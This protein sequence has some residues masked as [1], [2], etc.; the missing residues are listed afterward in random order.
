MIKEHRTFDYVSRMAFGV[1]IALLVFAIFTNSLIMLSPTLNSAEIGFPSSGTFAMLFDYS[2]N[3][4]HSMKMLGQV[5]ANI[6][7]YLFMLAAV[8]IVTLSLALI[9][10]NKRI[11]W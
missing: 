7:A 10:H 6:V 1:L 3:V 5:L 9:Q 8:V 4:G 2:R 11:K